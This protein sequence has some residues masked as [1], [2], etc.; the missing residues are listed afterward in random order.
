M[1]VFLQ[2]LNQR[3]PIVDPDTGQP[4]DYFME[5]LR[6]DTGALVAGVDAKADAGAVGDSGLTMATNRLLGRDTASTGA[7]EELTLSEALDLIGSAAQGDILYRG[8]SAWARLGAG[9]SG[10]YLKTLGAGANPTWAA[11]GGNGTNYL[12]NRL[13]SVFTAVTLNVNSTTYVYLG[14]AITSHI[15]LDE[16]PATHYRIIMRGLSNAAAQTVT[17]QLCAGI[18]A[19]T[20]IHTGGNDLVI[21]NTETVYDSGW[22]S[23]DD[24]ATGTPRYGMGIKGSNAT[25]DLSLIY[26][27]LHWAI[28]P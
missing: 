2:G 6:G 14:N 26:A 16:F 1:A 11:S 25:V 7:I 18:T 15:D 13:F 21:S 8:A 4:T 27:E 19:T 20:P 5:L 17:V 9:T 10:Y 22:L 12:I 23:R 3:F 28:N 24:G